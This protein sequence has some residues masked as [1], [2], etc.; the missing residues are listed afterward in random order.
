EFEVPAWGNGHNVTYSIPAGVQVL[1]LGYRQTAYPAKPVGSFTSSETW[2]NVLWAKAVTTLRVCMRDSFMDCPDRE[3]SPWP[4]D[5]AN[6]IELCGY[7]L[8]RRADHLIRK[9]FAELVGWKTPDGILWGAVPTGRFAESYR[10]FPAQSQAAIAV[11]LRDFWMQ[12]G[13]RSFLEAVYPAVRDYLLRLYKQ[14]ADGRVEHR[15]PWKTAW[16]PGTQSWYDWGTEPDAALMD[17]TWYASSLQ[18]LAA[19]AQALGKT[20]DAAECNTRWERI[21]Q[22]LPQ[23]WD[24]KQGGYRSPQFT[25]APDPRG[26]ALAV[27]AGVAPAAHQE[28]LAE[29]LR[30]RTTNSIYMEKHVVD[31]LFRL[32]R[33]DLALARI[34]QRYAFELASPYTTLPERFGEDSNHAWGVGPAAALIREIVGLKPDRPGWQQFSIQPADMAIARCAAT[35]PAPL[36]ALSVTVERSE[37]RWTL[38]IICPSGATGR[39]LLPARFQ[40][41]ESTP[42]ATAKQNAQ[43]Q[44]EMAIQPG[45]W[46]VVAQAR[47]L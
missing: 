7:A 29:L 1:D 41:L 33:P 11:G 3:R 31:A 27:C 37:E 18:T 8:D 24:D 12:S 4:G 10:E 25:F 16:G 45:R 32:D 47:E 22:F 42:T 23:W 28:S 15:G 43:G 46:T 5:Y 9:S 6:M 20:E 35:V 30:T 39:V 38:E 17:Q 2:M 21:R 19:F 34:R 26:N 44:W 36:G 13:D 14:D 40:R